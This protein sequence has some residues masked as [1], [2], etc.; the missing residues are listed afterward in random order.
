MRNGATG[1]ANRSQTVKVTGATSSTVVTLSSPAEMNAVTSTRT[2]S[3]RNGRPR[4]R[5]IAQIARY[6]N[7]PVCFT[8]ATISII[9]SSRTMTFQSIPASAEKNAC[10]ASV[11]P[12]SSI[13]TAP[14]S[15]AVTRWIFSV[16]IRT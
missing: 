3:T 8:T 7:A 15:A 6:S 5:R 16:A 13:T 9:P 1:T 2:T 4:A 14:P 11:A 10:S 12:I